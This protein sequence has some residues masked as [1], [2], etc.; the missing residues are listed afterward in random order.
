MSYFEEG[1]DPSKQTVSRLSSILSSHG[2]QLP[3]TRQKKQFY[4]DLFNNQL[5]PKAHIILKNMA[6]VV[7]SNKGITFVSPKSKIPIKKSPLKERTPNESKTQT[8]AKYPLL[9]KEVIEELV[10]SQSIIITYF[11]VSKTY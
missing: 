11:R 5:A 10:L 1:F 2:I 4:V 8:P 6:S 3:V 9:P 7:P